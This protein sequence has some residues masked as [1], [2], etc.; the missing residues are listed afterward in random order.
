[1]QDKTTRVRPAAPPPR[2]GPAK[3]DG[4][5]RA[6]GEPAWRLWQAR[7]AL[8]WERLWPALWAPA[9]LAGAFLALALANVLPLL[10]GWLH[11][12]VLALFAVAIPL[13]LYRGVR[14][15]SPP[16]AAAARRRIERDSGLTHRPLSA[17][18]DAPAGGGATA[19]ALWHLHQERMRRTVRR[20]RVALP[21]P[22]VA[23][24]DPLALR[25]LV[26]L[27][28]FVA[29]TGSWG[30]WRPRLAAAFSPHVAAGPAARPVALDLW[31]TP[32]EYTGLPP[33][34]L[35]AGADDGTHAAPAPAPTTAAGPVKVPAGSLALG[36]VTGGGVPPTLEI[37]GAPVAFEAV[38]ADS[39]QVQ[40]PVTGGDRVAVTQ[41]GGTL[42]SWPI[43]VVPDRPPTIAFVTPPAQTDHGALRIEYVAQ[44]DYGIAGAVGTVRLAGEGLPKALDG[45]PIE[46][47]LALPGLNPKEARQAGFHDLTAHPWAGLP[48]TLR[49]TATDGAGQTGSSEELPMILPERVFNHPVA[50]AIA[51]LRKRLTLDPEA[52]RP[53]AEA[54]AE[55]SA[56]P[57]QYHHDLVAF[58]AMRSAAARLILDPEASAVP[59]VQQLMWETALRIEDG[60]LSLA[61]RDLRDAER[62]LAEA[63]DRNAS[64]EELRQLMDELQQALDRFMEAMAENLRQ[65]LERGEQVPQIPPELAQNMMDQSDI[66]QMLDRMREMA[67]TGSRDAARQMLSQLQQMLENMR[68]GMTAQMQQGQNQAMET[69]RQLQDLMQQQQQ[70]MDQTFQRAQEQMNAENGLPQ[71]GG[72]TPRGR[73]QPQT[74]SPMM[75]QQAEQQEALRRQLGEMMR[76]MG[77]QMGD[78]PQPFGRAERAMRGAGEALQQGQPGAAVPN[79]AQAMQELQQGLQGMAEQMMQQMA[80]PGMMM[81]PPG[82]QPGRQPGRGRDPLNR[83]PSPFGQI[84]NGDVKVPAEADLQRAREILDELRRRSGEYD[85]PQMEREYIDRLLRQF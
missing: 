15:F 81:G 19:L 56:A 67:E 47:P 17:L 62:R 28:L 60:G 48:V 75:Q 78:I 23:A 16:D 69:M 7:A 20:L 65:A 73:G 4:A 14:R 35:K 44:D 24:R 74:S 13:A 18:R 53:V 85:R 30:D 83:N 52:R 26:G 29:V 3:P 32:P 54:L 70:L 41:D 51:E 39:F 37:G 49:L 10:P 72:R 31:L 80:G 22:N 76:Q 9:A 43:E 84:D 25:M 71:P 6:A 55:L 82:Q 2:R 1:M 77:E 59:S 68:A 38:D 36:R 45:E 79:Q 66:Q 34:F 40:A 57:G 46:L 27:L 21:H 50:R 8:T 63:L 5:A 12:A 33:I 61:E 64:D 42:G 58:L 11:A